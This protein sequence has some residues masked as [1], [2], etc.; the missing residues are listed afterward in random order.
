MLI[1]PEGTALSCKEA[2]E[3]CAL[4]CCGVSVPAVPA[5]VLALKKKTHITQTEI[6]TYKLKS[7][8]KGKKKLRVSGSE[9]NHKTA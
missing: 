2:G 7:F 3:E 8:A 1:V 4:T 5:S 9:V 6:I